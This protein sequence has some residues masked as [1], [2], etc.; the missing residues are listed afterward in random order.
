[1]AAKPNASKKENKEDEE[2]KE[3]KSCGGGAKTKFHRHDYSSPPNQIEHDILCA[4]WEIKSQDD[5]F[6]TFQ[7]ITKR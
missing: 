6:C 7:T 1:M 2:S 5:M 3:G 4:E